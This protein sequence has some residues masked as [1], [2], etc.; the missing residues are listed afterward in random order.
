MTKIHFYKG[1]RTIGGTVVE[2]ETEKSRCLFDFGIIYQ[3]EL[4]S[5]VKMR[6]NSIVRDYLKIGILPMISGIYDGRDIEGLTLKAW[7]DKEKEVFFLIS[8]MHID[9]MEA[10]GML[11]QEIP[12]YM[13]E[14]SLKLYEG[15]GEVSEYFYRINKNCRGV[16]VDN[17]Y[18]VGDITFRAAAIDHDVV[19]AC[20]YEIITED[21]TICYT[22]DYRLHGLHPETTLEFAEKVRGADVLI[23]EGVTVS[24]MEEAPESIPSSASMEVIPEEK[25][26]ITE[27]KNKA[28]ETEGLV[29]LNLYERNIERAYGLLR[30]LEEAGKKMVLEP[31]L[32]YFLYKFYKADQL[33]VY[34]PFITEKR[35]GKSILT[36]IFTPV[37]RETI[38]ENPSV[39][40]LQLSYGHI[41]E[42]LDLPLEESLYIHSNGVPLGDYDPVY[43]KLLNFLDKLKVPYVAMGLGGHVY[44]SQQKYFLERIGARYLVPVHTL[45][46]EKVKAAGSRQILPE[47]GSTYLLRNH[48]LEKIG[49]GV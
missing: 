48:C 41:L 4:D 30:T 12:V 39:Y 46:P 6:E 43:F 10:L 23:T 36:D 37:G 15:I 1:L 33:T 44:P 38:K 2:I 5:Q 20:G 27:I 24:F 45:A 29:F 11:A 16:Q 14:E 34:E 42:L 21:G 28:L 19:G 25:N 40:V 7:P 26:L 8:H 35:F 31:D 49:D 13:P 9:H 17:R 22:G 32:A 3:N 18:T 47:Q